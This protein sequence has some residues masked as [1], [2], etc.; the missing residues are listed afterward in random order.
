MYL[1]DRVTPAFRS[2]GFGVFHIALTRLFGRV[3]SVDTILVYSLHAGSQTPGAPDQHSGP[4]ICRVELGDE[5]LLTHLCEKFPEQDF[6]ERILNPGISCY[7]AILDEEVSGY[8]WTTQNACHIEEVDYLY[9]PGPDEFLIYDCFVS[10][11][12]R[13]SGIYPAMLR[14]I[15]RDHGNHH[16]WPRV[17]LIAVTSVNRSSIRGIEKVGFVQ[18]GSIIRA[19]LFGFQKWWHY[20]VVNHDARDLPTPG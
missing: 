5:W 7:V 2:Y 15:L 17:A 14:R 20:S 4:R 13:G 10:P 9:T 19:R 18:I 16:E 8:A 3:G 6:G 12:H 1:V 11:F